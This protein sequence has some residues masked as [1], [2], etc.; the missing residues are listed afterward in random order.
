[1]SPECSFTFGCSP[2]AMRRSADSGSPW[3]PVVSIT[4]RSSGKLSISLGDTSSP[5]G[6]SAWPSWRAMLRFLR[7]ERPTTATRRSSAIAA[8]ITCWRRCTL[9]ANDVTTTRPGAR[10]DHLLQDGPDARLRR[11]RAAPVGVGRVAAQ[12][13]H[14]LPAELREPRRIGG[15]AVHRRLVE[16]VVAGQDHGAQV[17]GQRD[18]A[19]VGDRVR[20]RGSSPG[21]TGRPRTLAGLDVVHRH[22][23]Q[24]VLLDLRARHRDR[25]RA[26][27]DR[28]T[29]RPARAAPRAARRRGPRGRA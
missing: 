3:L 22:V 1:M 5:S 10:A 6:T 14:P 26:A 7:I 12:Q 28:G 24:L 21:R 27:V 16:L 18:R 19:R 29:W 17:A 2:C 15:R 23:L 4:S 13:Q 25:E 11:R 9:D 8:S 20:R